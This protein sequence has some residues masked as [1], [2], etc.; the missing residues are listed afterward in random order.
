MGFVVYLYTILLYWFSHFF[1]EVLS[2]R[3]IFPGFKPIQTL[4]GNFAGSKTWNLP[5]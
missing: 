4:K 2:Q 5:S 3:F 1:L